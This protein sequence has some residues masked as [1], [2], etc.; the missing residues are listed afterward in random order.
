MTARDDARAESNAEYHAHLHERQRSWR[1][2]FA[3]RW[4]LWLLAA[5]IVRRFPI[6]RYGIR[7]HRWHNKLSD[8][9]EYAIPKRGW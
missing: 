1:N 9:A 8:R 6:G 2:V 5:V 3:L 7:R 4:R